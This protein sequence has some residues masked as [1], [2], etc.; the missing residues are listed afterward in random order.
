MQARCSAQR[1]AFAKEHLTRVTS[2]TY[3][4]STSLGRINGDYQ[5]QGFRIFS[6]LNSPALGS[7]QGLGHSRPGCT[8]EAGRRWKLE[9]QPKRGSA[10]GCRA[11]GI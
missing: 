6:P 4:L 2:F 7:T 8:R 11:S 3:I 9:S 10:L 1:A 5:T